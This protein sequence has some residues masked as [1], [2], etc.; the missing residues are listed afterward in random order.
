MLT[1]NPIANPNERRPI[2]LPAEISAYLDEMSQTF[3]QA[4]RLVELGECF[5]TA[6]FGSVV[7]TANKKAIALEQT[8][9]VPACQTDAIEAQTSK[10]VIKLPDGF[11]VLESTPIVPPT[12][13]FDYL[14]VKR[15]K[16]HE[17]PVADLTPGEARSL[18]QVENFNRQIKELA[19]AR[20]VIE[21]CLASQIP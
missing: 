18:S 10:S 15:E 21:E 7:V 2:E 6:S 4:L 17:R 14:I 12:I 13:D 19:L 1:P 11:L 8:H 3:R 16:L 20:Q 5:Q 9:F